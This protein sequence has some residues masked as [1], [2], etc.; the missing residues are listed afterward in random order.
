MQLYFKDF[1]RQEK[2]FLTTPLYKSK[3]IKLE[4]FQNNVKSFQHNKINFMLRISLNL[5]KDKAKMVGGVSNDNILFY[6]KLS[7]EY[8]FYHTAK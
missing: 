4:K 5:L 6:L 7:N 2:E 1:N 3:Y 8:A